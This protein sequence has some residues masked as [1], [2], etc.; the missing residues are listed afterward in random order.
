MGKELKKNTAL[1]FSVESTSQITI[2]QSTSMSDFSPNK[3]TFVGV[4]QNAC[5]VKRA[6]MFNLYYALPYTMVSSTG[7]HSQAPSI[8]CDD[9]GILVLALALKFSSHSR[10]RNDS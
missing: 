9:Y 7:L 5:M 10:V 2:P 6:K 4:P 3:K 1:S 8:L